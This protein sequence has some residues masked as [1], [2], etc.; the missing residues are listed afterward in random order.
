MQEALNNIEK[1]AR[2]KIVQLQVAVQGDS[3]VLRIKDDGHGFDPGAAPSGK[4]KGHGIGLTNMRERASSLGGSC[5]VKTAPK[6]GTTIIVRV[7][8]GNAR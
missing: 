4:R 8:C 1:H 2:A 5:E 3:L 7:P 6:R